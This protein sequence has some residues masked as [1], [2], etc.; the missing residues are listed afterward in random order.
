MTSVFA[1]TSKQGP[2]LQQYRRRRSPVRYGNMCHAL[3]GCM[4]HVIQ[5]VRGDRL[6]HSGIRLV[7]AIIRYLESRTPPRK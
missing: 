7:K 2:N 3:V 1:A 5:N 4:E 6:L